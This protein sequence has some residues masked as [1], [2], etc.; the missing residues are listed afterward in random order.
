M[1]GNAWQPVVYFG[2]G[3][4]DP[5]LDTERGKLEK[6]DTGGCT[7][8]GITVGGANPLGTDIVTIPPEKVARFRTR[9]DQ[10]VAHAQ[11]TPEDGISVAYLNVA[12][13]E[14]EVNAVEWLEE[15][16]KVQLTQGSTANAL[17][18]LLATAIGLQ[19]AMDRVGLGAEPPPA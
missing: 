10:V 1:A 16:A 15:T 18:M 7:I 19:K 2:D 14:P 3:D 8:T 11:L 6:L 4:E 9:L 5:S 17:P 13:S 12:G